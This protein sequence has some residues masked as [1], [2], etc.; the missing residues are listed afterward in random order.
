MIGRMVEVEQITEIGEAAVLP[1]GLRLLACRLRLRLPFL[2]CLVEWLR[3]VVPLALGLRPG[4]K[5][6]SAY[7][8]WRF[9]ADVNAG[10]SKY[11]DN[12]TTSTN[13]NRARNP[14]NHLLQHDKSPPLPQPRTC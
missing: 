2:G 10:E 7:W 9:C 8:R 3:Q 11:G 5:P 14:S 6:C 13:K 1:F 4:K 12:K